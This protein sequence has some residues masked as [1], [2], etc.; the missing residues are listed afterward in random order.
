M[1]SG[2]R[3]PG[4]R[5]PSLCVYLRHLRPCVYLRH[6]RPCGGVFSISADLVGAR[7]YGLLRSTDANYPN[8]DDPARARPNPRRHSYTV[9]Y[10]LS[11][12]ERNTEDFNF[13]PTSTA[14]S[15]RRPSAS[16]QEARS[17]ARCSL[18]FGL[19]SS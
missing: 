9:A 11:T 6:L 10:T 12:T 19:I 4:C 14:T 5:D 18:A 3:R 8:L 15:D 13:F 1:K 16:R 17:R 2:R 7:G